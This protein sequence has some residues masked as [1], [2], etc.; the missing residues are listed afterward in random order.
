MEAQGI[1]DLFV[2]GVWYAFAAGGLFG[3]FVTGP[4]VI[5]AWEWYSERQERKRWEA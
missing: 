4:L 5:A 1:A 3:S 2:E